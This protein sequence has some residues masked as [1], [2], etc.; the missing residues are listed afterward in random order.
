MVAAAAGAAGAGV[1][2]A[3]LGHM[4][5]F[6]R[7]ADVLDDGLLHFLH[8]F[9]GIEKILGN[10]VAQEGFAQLLEGGD[11]RAIQR[12]AGL[13]FLLQRL[14]F[15]HEGLIL[16]AD[17]VIGHEGFDIPPHGLDLR[18]FENG[19]AKFLRFLDNN[20]FFSLSLHN[21]FSDFGGQAP[22]FLRNVSAAKYTTGG[23]EKQMIV[24]SLT[25][26]K[27]PPS[28][29]GADERQMVGKEREAGLWKYIF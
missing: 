21:K 11:F 8:I 24:R 17:L 10:R 18:L 28:L 29:T 3:F 12:R 7:F 5:E 26:K 25:D 9:L 19:L 13:L 1:H 16:T 6:K 4:A 22:V 23:A 14:A 20:G 15:G 27:C 2:F